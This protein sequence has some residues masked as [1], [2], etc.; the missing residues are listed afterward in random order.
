MVQNSCLTGETAVMW[1]QNSMK[2]CDEPSA[3]R[4]VPVRQLKI[5]ILGGYGTFGG[6]LVRLLADDQRFTLVVAGRSQERAEAFCAGLNCQATLVACAFD[7]D[8]DVEVQLG[9]IKPDIVVD[10]SGPFQSYGNNLYPLAAAAIALKLHYLDLSD[11]SDF[12]K[13]IAKFDR[14]AREAAVFVLSGVSSVPVLTAAA[15][16]HLSL[17][18]PP[19]KAISAGI[20]PSPYARVGLSVTRAIASYAGKPVS[21][22]RNGKPFVGHALTETRRYTIAPPGRVGLKSRRFSLVDVPDLALLPELWPTLGSVWFGAGLVPDFLHRILNGLAWLV[23]WKILAS[24]TP[25]APFMHRVNDLLRWGEDRGGMF[26]D[27]IGVRDDGTSVRRSWHLVAEG[28]DGPFIPSMPAAAII[29]HCLNGRFPAFGARPAVKEL[30][31]YDYAPLFAGRRIATGC[32]EVSPEAQARPLYRRLLE[33]AW[34]TLP[35]PIRQMHDL[36]DNLVAKGSARVQRGRGLSARLIAGMVGFPHTGSDVPV[37][38]SFEARLGCEHWRRTFNS[39]SFSS[40]QEAGRGRFEH[41]L[42]ERFGPFVFGM[43]LVIE[44]GRM[45]L[46]LRRWT[47]LGVP[48]P[49]AWAPFGTIYEEV[50]NGRFCFHVEIRHPLT[51]LI[52]E[53]RGWLVPQTPASD[54]A[55]QTPPNPALVRLGVETT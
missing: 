49:V 52:V 9:A 24:L 53:Y 29:R 13:G 32:R 31:L 20:A 26:V 42:C 55:R 18:F 8:A 41:L 10:A 43:A 1:L 19:I 25:L 4:L 16:R 34:D 11:S 38:V 21:L 37:E 12:V 2:A 14:A 27:I 23:R 28:D 44:G 39:R 7:R 22:L 54:S 35:E 48:M 33:D 47:F 45:R 40:T 3:Q 30:E 15:V 6:R 17:G 51:G 46:V 36:T 50:D 5:L